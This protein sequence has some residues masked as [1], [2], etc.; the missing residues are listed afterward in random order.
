MTA[1]PH[2]LVSPDQAQQLGFD[3]RPLGGD[4]P[5]AE[6]HDEISQNLGGEI[7]AAISREGFGVVVERPSIRFDDEAVA[8]EKVDS[9]DTG[10]RDLRPD[11]DPARSQSNADQRLDPRL[12]GA[13]GAAEEFDVARSSAKPSLQLGA[14]D[15]TFLERGVESDDRRLF[16]ETLDRDIHSSCDGIAPA[17]RGVSGFQPVETDPVVA[18]GMVPGVHADMQPCEWH[19]PDAIV[20]QRRSAAQGATGRH[21]R[22]A[23][24]VSAG[25]SEP[26]PSDAQDPA[27]DDGSIEAVLGR[28]T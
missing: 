6:S 14:R 1:S 5:V 21:C 15:E 28:T 2:V 9:T 27:R 16:V 10:D 18:R 24:G 17:V 11:S 22:H 25:D 13:I 4:L 8:D 23:F 26:S 19:E 12:A 20:L 7:A 3:G